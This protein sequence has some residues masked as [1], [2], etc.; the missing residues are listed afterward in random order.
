M[1]LHNAKGLEFPVV[2]ITGMEEGVFPHQRSLDEQNLEEER[3]LAYVGIT[4]AMDRL[5]L[6]HARARNLWGGSLYGLPSR[7]LGEIPADLVEEQRRRR[8]AY[9][10]RLVGRRRLGRRLA[11]A[12]R[13]SLGRR[14]LVG[15][16][17]RDA[18]TTTA[19]AGSGRR[20]TGLE[21]RGSTRRSSSSSSRPAT[22]CC[23]R[24]SARARCTAAERAASSSCASRTTA[25]ERRLMAS[26][27]P[28][29][30]LRA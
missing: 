7:F 21:K 17:W 16:G 5:Y 10:R 8:P 20:I 14:R 1:T 27:A 4:R 2:F 11:A 22:G 24:P 6:L 15:G 18:A 13:G 30:K 28:L 25:R 9:G 12:A 19:S 26:I 29:R 23:T 3:R